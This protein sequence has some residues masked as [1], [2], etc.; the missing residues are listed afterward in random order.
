MCRT[1]DLPGISLAR[2]SHQHA[3]PASSSIKPTPGTWRRAN[4]T[5]SRRK[6]STSSSHASSI[7]FS[8]ESVLSKQPASF[9]PALHQGARMLQQATS[10]TAHNALALP[11][12]IKPAA[13]A[14]LCAFVSPLFDRLDHFHKTNTAAAGQAL[15]QGM[16]LIVA[17]PPAAV[18]SYC[19][20]LHSIQIRL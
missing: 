10:S 20:L 17:T 18:N 4:S 7:K 16:Q 15:S 13:V 19:R 1:R 11:L 8:H 5:R 2:I 14:A 3:A 12:V 9:V 6:I